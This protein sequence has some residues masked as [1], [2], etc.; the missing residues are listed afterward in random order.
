MQPGRDTERP[1][2]WRHHPRGSPLASSTTPGRRPVGP[3]AAALA[4]VAALVWVAG[5]ATAHADRRDEDW[6]DSLGIDVAAGI[7]GKDVPAAWRPV[8]VTLAPDAPVRGR[9][10]VAGSH[11]GGTVLQSRTVEVGAGA[12]KRYHVLVPPEADVRVQVVADEGDRVATVT[13]RRDVVDGVL[14]G[15]LDP[16]DAAD[17]P[18]TTL[19]TT[20][21]RTTAVTVEDG[22]LDLGPRALASLGTL[23]ARQ[24]NLAALPDT[25]RQAVARYVADGGALVVVGANDP[26]LGLPWRPFT[27]GSGTGLVAAP[28]A[29]GAS[30]SAIRGTPGASGG[31][32]PD[33]V[34]VAAGRGRVVAT[35]YDLGTEML[36]S[37]AVWEHLAQPRPEASGA[38]LRA[39][40]QLPHL[41]EQAFGRVVGAPPS[42]G[43]LAAFFLVYVLVAGPV[44]GV[45]LSRRRRPEVAWV[46]LPVVTALFV[47]GAFAGATGARP[48][49]GA[50]ATIDT[51][52]D[53][54]GTTRAVAGV[55]APQAGQRVVTLPG[56][57]WAV[58][59]ASWDGSLRVDEGDDTAVTLVQPGQSFGGLV[60]QRPVDAP[61]PLELEVAVFVDETRIEVTNTSGRDVDD[62]A[63]RLGTTTS[64]LAATLPA[65]E[66][67]V[68]SLPSPDPLPAQPDLFAGG[69]G[70]PFD[71]DPGPEALAGLV[72]WGPLDGAPGTVWVTATTPTADHGVAIDGT[73]PVDHG[74]LVAVGSTPS[75][76]DDATVP[77]EVQRDVV[78]AGPQLAA[79]APLTLSGTGPATLRFRLP[80]EG[81]VTALDLALERGCCPDAAAAAPAQACGRVEA[82]DPE[83]GDVLEVRDACGDS[84]PCPPDASV[85][86]WNED[87]P[88]PAVEGQACFDDGACHELTWV[89]PDRKAPPPAPTAD[90]QVW[91]HTDRRWVDHAEVVAEGATA[92]PGRW[93]GPL[94]D[95]WVRVTGELGPFDVAPQSVAATLGS[96]P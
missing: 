8:S 13:P 59:G 88:G 44:V 48:R 92:Q 43:W 83:T 57:G 75:L 29:W 25:H 42:V 15:V 38:A 87:A 51:W 3:R 18:A 62:L 86:S 6:A 33:V 12:E 90:M 91:D 93:V 77:L 49:V 56:S 73:A 58:Q 2:E 89:P 31:S 50:A 36:S 94:G 11:P 26:D 9:L 82:R 27:D 74:R 67:L 40:E 60:A 79:E 39:S 65:G 34:A 76:T 17:V 71:L 21:Q 46:V 61:P 32:D 70:G 96:A 72:R 24:A 30:V 68:E 5:S 85:C 78:D 14:V 63:V 64:H 55:R 28:G 54:L 10:L 23:V 1:T 52:V 81:P 95:L 20:D 41:L 80:A 69:L 16:L 84:P 19:P 35:P 7:A 47:G 53:G 45:V 22:V 4:L 66:T 37:P